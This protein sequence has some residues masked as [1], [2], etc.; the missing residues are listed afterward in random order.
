MCFI[1]K[2]L[3]YSTLALLCN[4]FSLIANGDLFEDTSICL[5]DFFCKQNRAVI[6]YTPPAHLEKALILAD[7][8]KL[9]DNDDLNQKILTKSI[10][11]SGTFCA[12]ICVKKNQLLALFILIEEGD[13]AAFD[14]GDNG[15]ANIHF[16]GVDYPLDLQFY[17]TGIA[18]QAFAFPEI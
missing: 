8:L 14:S 2:L 9:I 16:N 1:N 6:T 11:G 4:T 13:I 12:K 7:L 5:P 18:V 10:E 3:M 17:E 15:S